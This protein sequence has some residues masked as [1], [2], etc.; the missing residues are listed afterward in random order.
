MP[1]TGLTPAL[2]MIVDDQEANLRLLGRVLSDAGFDVMPASSGAQ[3]L[4]RLAVETPDVVLLDM[5]MPDMNGFAVLERIRGEPKWADIPVLFLTAAHERDLLVRAFEAGAVDY[6]T[7]PF[8]S[9]ELIVRVRTHSEHKRY[10]DKLRQTI[11]EREDL[12]TIIVH[13]LKNPLFNISLNAGMILEAG[14][15][16]EEIATRAASIETSAK[17]AMDFVERYLGKR[18]SLEL[19][20]RCS[21]EAHTP[22][23][24]LESVAAELGEDAGRR[25]QRIEIH[26]A[27][28]RQQVACDRDAALLILRNLLSNAIKYAPE[29]STIELGVH[30]GAA[31]S[32]RLWVADRGPGISTEQQAQLFKRYVR[33]SAEPKDAAASSGVGLALARQE[34]EW[35]GGEL[36]YEPRPEQGSV[37]V[38]KLPQAGPQTPGYQAPDG[39]EDA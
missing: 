20:A 36:W 5:R 21:V 17:R 11:R 6:L 35:M 16:D 26:A 8:V 37:F 33:L 30:A 22:R 31:G 32:L 12:A 2:V 18:A 19:R 7:K 24:L 10:R 3:A 14:S 38:L 34:A 25:R 29:D 23:A 39:D 4:E 15:D 9:E 13:D 1:L 28:M 27:T